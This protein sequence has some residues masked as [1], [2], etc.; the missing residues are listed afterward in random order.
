MGDM[1]KNNRG[2]AKKKYSNSKSDYLNSK[3]KPK[4]YKNYRH[5]VFMMD[6]ERFTL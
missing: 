3:S 1:K 2:S 4:K 6:G 5:L